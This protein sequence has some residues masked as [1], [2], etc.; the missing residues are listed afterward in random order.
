M[1]DLVPARFRT[2]DEG[3]RPWQRQLAEAL[4][5]PPDG[6]T[7][8]FCHD[9][10]PGRTFLCEYL[11]IHKRGYLLP[12]CETPKMVYTMLA[13]TGCVDPKLFLVDL[14]RAG[15]AAGL[16]AEVQ[17]LHQGR[18]CCQGREWLFAPPRV[19]VLAPRPPPPGPSFRVWTLDPD[20]QL[21]PMASAAQ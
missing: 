6:V 13:A 4:A 11:H 19:A 8:F 7:D 10:H 12:G 17:A 9:G 14:P 5:A 15:D 16:L 21:I 18:V 2:T 1:S 20:G 3:L